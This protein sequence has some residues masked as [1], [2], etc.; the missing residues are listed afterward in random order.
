M[1]HTFQATETNGED[2]ND[3]AKLHRPLGARRI[4]TSNACGRFG[5]DVYSHS[6]GGSFRRQGH[7]G[8]ERYVAMVLHPAGNVSIYST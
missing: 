5:L 8:A 2:T 1:F 7:A 3:A 4:T 6:F